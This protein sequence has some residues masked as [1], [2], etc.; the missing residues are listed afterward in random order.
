MKTMHFTI[1]GLA[2]LATTLVLSAS[3]SAETTSY[4]GSGLNASAY[5]SDYDDF[6]QT[7]TYLYAYWSEN[8]Q[9]VA[10]GAADEYTY[11]YVYYSTYTY[12][13]SEVE[14]C[15]GSG[16]VTDQSI[17]NLDSATASCTLTLY[18][19]VYNYE[20]GEYIDLGTK[21]VTVDVLLEGVGSITRSRSSGSYT[22]PSHFNSTYNSTGQSRQATPTVL[23]DDEMFTASEN[24]YCGGY[25]SKGKWNSMYTINP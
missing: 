12:T 10:G 21:D 1:G 4:H 13:G 23:I 11:G 7:S 22:D 17:S 9:R 25:L 8:K 2:L 5:C 15:Y 16:E 20:T 24:S 6:T 14:E 18:C 3:L 19:Y